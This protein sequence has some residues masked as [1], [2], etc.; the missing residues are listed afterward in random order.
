MFLDA[1]AGVQVESREMLQGA[2]D[3]LI[4]DASRRR[5]LGD[6]ARN[7]VQANRGAV[8]KTIEIAREALEQ[9]R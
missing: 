1:D 2:I 3:E 6:N 9:K 7:L 4:Q 8:R 5:E